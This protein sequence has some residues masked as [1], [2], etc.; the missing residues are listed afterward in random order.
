M[1]S[2]RG[3]VKEAAAL[4]GVSRRQVHVLID[5]YRAWLRQGYGSDSCR[6]G[7][8]RACTEEGL[9]A[10]ARSTVARRV[11]ELHP[12]TARRREGED[13]VPSP[14]GGRRYRSRNLRPLANDRG[15]WAVAVTRLVSRR[16]RLRRRPPHPPGILDDRRT[17]P[18]RWTV[19]AG[20]N[21][22]Q[23]YWLGD[24]L[25]PGATPSEWHSDDSQPPSW[26]DAT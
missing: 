11:A 23:T 19:L 3:A 15:R 9:P 14:A 22:D 5:R 8:G 21:P 18:C 17:S 24:V 12:A 16:R 6:S 13:A 25:R 10:P 26:T 4:L 20:W 2:G 1:S 7:G